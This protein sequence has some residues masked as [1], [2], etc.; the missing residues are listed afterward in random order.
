MR[1]IYMQNR[2][3]TEDS[4]TAAE[5]ANINSRFAARGISLTV[6]Q[7]AFLL[8]LPFFDCAQLTD[9][10][11]CF[12]IGG[13][14]VRQADVNAVFDY[15]MNACSNISQDLKDLHG[16]FRHFFNLRLFDCPQGS[17]NFRAL[18][19]FLIQYKTLDPLS[20]K[21]HDKSGMERVSD[22]DRTILDYDRAEALIRQEMQ[23]LF[24]SHLLMASHAAEAAASVV[25]V[26]SASV[27]AASMAASAGGAAPASPLLSRLGL[28]RDA[29][30]ANPNPIS[31]TPG[32]V[33]DIVNL[34]E[35]YAGPMGHF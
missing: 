22:I 32:S 6:N 15:F 10:F 16:L 11:T 21:V 28:F 30:G 35:A 33:S 5:M 25:A 27:A 8:S 14:N 2:T 20:E 29:I 26:A 31:N 1:Y 24:D 19:T 18:L 12:R 3:A 9:I 17:K 13:Q 4:L 7:R 23:A 34:V